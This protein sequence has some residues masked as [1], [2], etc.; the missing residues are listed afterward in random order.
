MG[1]SELVEVGPSRPTAA[2][3][4]QVD[5]ADGSGWKSPRPADPATYRPSTNPGT[6][7]AGPVGPAVPDRLQHQRS[8]PFRLCLRH[9]SGAP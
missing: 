6:S 5:V 3:G 9:A 4:D 1:L 7:L 8:A 2:H